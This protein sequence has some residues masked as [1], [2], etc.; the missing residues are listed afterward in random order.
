[1]S[2]EGVYVKISNK[3]IYD[4]KYEDIEKVSVRRYP[5]DAYI[6]F[7]FLKKPSKYLD[8]EQLNRMIKARE[9]I[10][11]AGNIAIPFTITNEKEEVILETINYYLNQLK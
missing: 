3:L 10:P 4:V 9:S 8:E 5:N 1:M 6:I 7:I 11:D 2:S